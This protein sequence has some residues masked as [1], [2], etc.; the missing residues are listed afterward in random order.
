MSGPAR[1]SWLHGVSVHPQVKRHSAA[2]EFLKSWILADAQMLGCSTAAAS[3]GVALQE[4]VV[5]KVSN[6][7]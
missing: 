1:W 5:V 3:G 2:L 4:S 6:E 7:V